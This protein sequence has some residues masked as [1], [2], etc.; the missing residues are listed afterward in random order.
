MKNLIRRVVRSVIDNNRFLTKLIFERRYSRPDP[1][2]A[3]TQKEIQKFIYGFSL[4]KGQFMSGLEVGC[5]EGINTWRVA[6]HCKSVLGLDLSKNA[7]LRAREAYPQYQFREFDLVNNDLSEKFDY[8]FCADTL[9]Y[10]SPTQ[11]KKAMEKIIS[12]T[13][14]EG[15]IHLI[16]CR[17]IRDDSEGSID[18]PFAAK[19]IHNLFASHKSLGVLK[20]QATPDYMVTIYQRVRE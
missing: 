16:H 3:K 5:G 20:D 6:E 15:V 18:K 7:I 11:L 2:N 9:Y 8:I 19:T 1:Y 4:L 13:T 17:S 12:W 14:R 10:L